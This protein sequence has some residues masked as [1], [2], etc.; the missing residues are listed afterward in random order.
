M[1][2]LLRLDLGPVELRLLI[3][4]LVAQHALPVGE[5]AAVAREALR[6]RLVDL[7]VSLRGERQPA[8]RGLW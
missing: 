7:W 2:D 3:D 4:A 8:D 5:A 6:R 1:S